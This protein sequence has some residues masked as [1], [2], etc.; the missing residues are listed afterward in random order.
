MKTNLKN[1]KP[2]RDISTD[3]GVLRKTLNPSLPGRKIARKGFLDMMT[4][5]TS[6]KR[7]VAVS[8]MGKRNERLL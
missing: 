5:E 7:R 8:H 6:Q 4:P 3:C 1:K 2:T